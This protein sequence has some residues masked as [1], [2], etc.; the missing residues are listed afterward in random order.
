[1]GIGGV[2]VVGDA[3]VTDDELNL[4]NH[5]TRAQYTLQVA[6]FDE[7]GGRTYREAAEAYARQLRAQG[8]QA[9]YLHGRTM[10]LVT[11]GLFSEQD[12]PTERAIGADGVPVVSQ[13]YGQKVR[14]LQRR[15]PHNLGNGMT[16][17]ESSGDGPQREAPSFVVRLPDP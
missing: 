1:L 9:F 7:A 16:L 4:R 11:V 13:R 5:L 3:V 12:V 8:E 6:F 15:F 17:L 2:G 10:S 14:A